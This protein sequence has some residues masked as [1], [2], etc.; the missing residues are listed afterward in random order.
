MISGRAKIAGIV[1]WPVAHSLSPALH[2]FWL[3]A[4][5][6]DGAYIPLAVRREDFGTVID[7]LKRAGFRGVNVTV[8]HKE[9]AFALADKADEAATAAGAANLLLF[10]ESGIEAR[11]TD[12][13]GLA[14]SLMLDPGRQNV[15]GKTVVLLGAGGAARAVILALAYLGVAEIR[16]IAREKSKADILMHVF[17]SKLQAPVQ[18]YGWN[19]WPQAAAGIGMLI[20]A[21]S[22]GM[23]GAEPLALSLEHLPLN[24]IVCDLVYNPL[25]THL[26][27]GAR[28]LGHRTVDGLGMLMH[29]AVPSFEAFYGEAPKVTPALR[30]ELK[31][32]L[33]HG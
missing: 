12:A 16:V 3:G 23:Q 25:D 13:A 6:I 20:N 14:A 32:A 5:G 26:L 8:P 18:A 9:A 4:H 7:A 10:R 22:G 30:A 15:Q 1:G 31:K 24:T 19:E 33:R 2:N 27:L 11:N 17:A 28:A 29:Q 21:T